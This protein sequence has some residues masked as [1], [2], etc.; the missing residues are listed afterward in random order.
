MATPNFPAPLKL[1]DQ[2][3]ILPAGKAVGE[4]QAALL[5]LH[6]GIA[7]S[8]IARK[9]L[10]DSTVQAL[11]A[12][13]AQVG[14]A[15]DGRI[16]PRT[17]EK[18]NAELAHRFVADSK[19]RTR[20]LQLLLEQ[21][22]QAVD[23]TEIR[24]R[25]FGDSTANALM[26]A[27]GSLG[28]TQ[29]GRVNAA[30]FER[31]REAA[32]AA[33]LQSKA[34]VGQL[35]RTLLRALRTAK[36]EVKVAPGELR[37]RTIGPSTQAAIQALQKKYHLR[38]TG[39]PDAATVDRMTSIAASIPPLARLL[40]AGQAADLQQLK[41]A[42]RLNMRSAHV[43]DVQRAL[44][45]LGFAVRES[46]FRGTVFGKSTRAAVVTYQKA[47]GLEVTGH[48]DGATLQSMNREIRR[49]NGGDAGESSPWR[50]RGCVR[51]A[52]WQ[53]VSRATV[54]VWEHPVSGNGARLAERETHG[55]GF[56]DLPYAPPRDPHT[57]RVREPFRLLVKVLRP[58][59]SQVG[60]RVLFNPTQIA[61]AN[62]T[63]G[64]QPYRGESVFDLRMRV[65]R[66]AAGV[67]RVAD[68]VETPAQRQVSAAAQA[69]GLLPE[70][71]MQLLLAHKVS[72]ALKDAALGPEA[73]YA[74]LAQKLPPN[75]PGDLIGATQDWT[76]VDELVTQATYGLVFM[77]DEAKSNAFGQ[78]IT[79]NLMP[80]AVGR[81]QEE[82]LLQFA[83]VKRRF[84]LAEPI[85][86]GNG[87]LDAVL[88]SSAVDAGSYDDV[89]DTFLRH[90]GFGAAFWQDVEARPADF[91]GAA[92]VADLKATVQ[93][94][95]VTKNFAPLVAR[96]KQKMADPG[97]A[98]MQTPR[99]LA[100]LT[101]D[102]WVGILAAGGNAVPPGTDAA[103]GDPVRTY[104]STLASTSERLFPDVALVAEVAR[105]GG[106]ALARVAQVQQVMDANPEL[107]LRE[108]NIDA[109]VAERHLAVEPDTLAEARVLQ[110][111]S[112]IAPS[113][114]T[115][116]LLV[117]NRIH[118][119]A[120]IVG[121]GQEQFVAQLT[122][123]PAVDTRTARTMYQVAESRYAGVLQRLA[124]YRFE[125]HRADPRA[126]VRHT[127]T[128]TE[129]A[130]Y[131]VA[132][133]ETLFGS[134]DYCAC[135]HC[136]SVY[137]P[138]AYLAD[139]LRFLAAHRS[140]V[141]NRSVADLFFARRPDVRALKLNCRNTETALPY[142][143][144]VNE[145]LEAAV[146]APQPAPAFAFQST[147]TTAEL[148]AAPENV[149]EAAY[150]KLRSADFPPTMSFDLW[151][152]QARVFLQHLGVPRW[153]LM[154]AFQSRPAAGAAAPSAGSI[155]G[156]FWGLSTHE[157]ALVGAQNHADADRQ[158][159][160]WG[161]PANA[162]LPGRLAVSDFLRRSGLDYVQL[163]A[164]LHADWVNPPGAANP[165]VIERPEA[166]CNTD[167]QQLAN[168]D[169]ARLDRIHRFLRL[170]RRT[171]WQ[172]WELDL[173]LR[174]GP[175]GNGTLDVNALAALQKF[176]QV[177]KRLGLNVERGLALYGDIERRDR[178]RPE[179]PQETVPALYQS[180]FL[181]RA[182]IS[183]VD[184][185][186]NLPLA[187][188]QLDD[189]KGT[190]LAAFGIS[191]ADLARIRARLPDGALT[192]ANLS[193][194][195]RYAWLAQGLGLAVKDLLTFESLAGIA[196]VFASP[197]ATSDFIERLDWIRK[198]G[199]NIEELDYALRRSPD[200][201]LGLRDE[202]I[203][204][205]AEALRDAIRSDKTGNAAGVATSQVAAALQVASE[206]AK[207]LAE[208]C[209]IGSRTVAAILVE[210]NFLEVDAQG[211][212][213]RAATP[214]AF[215]DLF[216][217][218]RALHKATTVVQRFKL[219]AKNL[220]WLLAHA[221]AHGLLRVEALPITA[222]PA[223]PLFP[224]WLNL[225]K[226][227][228]FKQIHPEP[229][230]TSLRAVLDLAAAAATT[231]A[232]VEQDLAALT[233]WDPQEVAEIARA[234]ALNQQRAQPQPPGSDFTVIDNYVR[235]HQARLLAWR[236][237]VAPARAAAWA[238]RDTEANQAPLRAAQEARQAAKAKYDEAT[239]LQ[240]VTPLEDTLRERKR[241]ALIAYL[242]ARSQTTMAPTIVQGTQVYANPEYFRDP[243]DLLKYYLI[244]VEMC[245][246]QLTSR[247]K[248][249]ISSVQMFV[250]RC[251]LG[252]EQPRVEVSRSQQ[253]EQVSE[254]SWRQW[255]WMKNYRVW[256]ANRKV[257]LYPENWI[258]PE[259]RDD[260]SPFF[261]EFEEEL[262][263]ADITD[264]RA[265][266]ALLRYLE[267]THEVARLDIVGAYHELDDSDT[268]DDLPP[269]INRLHVIG[270]TRT[271]PTVHYY[272]NFD[273]NR[274]EWTAWERIDLDIESE[275]VVPVV[276]NR[277][278]H[279][280]WLMFLEKPQKVKRLPAAQ[281]SSSV[282]NP[283]PPNV[284]EIQ[285][286]WSARAQ[287]G[288]ASKRVS[289][290]KLVHPWQRPRDSY[291]LK[292]RYKS[293]TNLLWVDLYIS[294]SPG[295]NSTRF[296][297]PYR[298]SLR[299]VTA[300]HPHDETARPWHAS[301]FVFDG[302][303]VDIRMRA[304]TGHYH[305]LGPD[306]VPT[307][308][309]TMTDSLEYVRANFGEL[310]RAT[311]GLA[312]GSQIAPRLPLPDGMHYSNT[313][314]ANNRQSNPRRANVLERSQSR[315]LLNR[316]IAPFEIVASQHRI[317]FDTLDWGQVPFF[318]QDPRRAWFVRPE[319]EQVMA[320]SQQTVQRC[321]YTFY[322]FHHPYTALFMRELRRSGV[323]GLLQRRIQVAPED[324]HPANPF[325]FDDYDPADGIA[326]PDA[327]TGRR[328]TVDFER[329]GAYAL[330]NWELFFHAPLL[331]ACKLSQN[332][333]FEEAMRW[334]HFIFDPTNVESAEVPQRYWV[335][336]P[337]FE[338]NSEAYRR[339]RI[340]E[341]LRNIDAHRDQLTAWK[342]NP[343]K[344][345]LI[346][347][348]RPVAYQK[349]VV[350][351]YIDNLIA[352][353]DHLFRRDTIEAINEAT[354]LY[355]L[356]Y[357]IL[358]RRP[359]KV[360]NVNATD[361]SYA[362]LTQQ[363]GLDAFGNKRVE[364]LLENHADARVR[365]TRAPPGTEPLPVLDVSYFGI[366]HNDQMLAY[367][368]R[369]ED[370]LYKI[371]HCMNIQGVVRQLPLFEPPIDPAL[372][373]K[374]AAAGVD[375]DSA[376]ADLDL[377]APPYR[378]RF[379]VAKAQELCAVARALGDK[380][381]AVL[382]KSDGEALALLRSRHEQ[383]LLKAVREI[384][385]QQIKE[386]TEAMAGLQKTRELADQRKTFYEGREFIN[387]WEGAAL[388]LGGA[389]AVA[390]T[391]IALGYVLAGGL[392]FIPGFVTGAS[393]FGGSP[394]VT[395]QVVDG[396]KFS[397][398][399]ELATTTLGAI[400]TALD[401]YA[402]LSSAVGGYQ[403]RQDEWTFQAQQAATELQQIDRQIAAA[404]I[405]LA[406]AEKELE[407]QELQIDNAQAV[408]EYM[409]NKYTNRQLYDWQV[410]QLSAVYF[411]AYQLAYDIGKRA[412]KCFRQER[413]DGT[414]VFVQFGHWDSLKGGLLAGERLAND[415][416][417]MEAAFLIDNARDLEL[418]RH[419][420][421]AQHFPLAL[422]EL[423]EAGSCT[424]RLDE[425][426]FDMDHPGH[427]FR[428]LKSVS[429]S[430]PSVV[431]PYTSVNCRLTLV[432]N[433]IRVDGGLS[434]GYGDPLAAAADTRFQQGVVAQRAI[435]TSHGQN[436]AGM[437]EVSFNDERYLPFE[438]AGAVSEWRLE[439]PRD[440]NQFDIATV[441]DVVLHVRYTAR[442]SGNPAFA[443][444]AR[445][446]LDTLL[447]TSGARLFMLHRE[448]ASEWH[449]FLHPGGGGAQ[450]LRLA[451]GREHLPF[452]ARD[453]RRNVTLTRVVLVADGASDGQF[454]VDLA[455]PGQAAI[456]GLAL[457]A[458]PDYGN[459]ATVSRAGFPQNAALVGDWA[460]TVRRSDPQD[461]APIA[462]AELGNAY[463]VLAFSART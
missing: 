291:N 290:Q 8:D 50:V 389:S 41:K 101:V 175:V 150:D 91:G 176:S 458:D 431:G 455:S 40:K 44:A 223:A 186:F 1:A 285:L 356:A 408:D 287:D 351:K 174:A 283:E 167:L 301:S 198:A 136:R 381:L 63:E 164:L 143:D 422:L 373:V 26:K 190:V 51:D 216:N 269:D 337:F 247:I 377:P 74:F 2:A 138:A 35:Q 338:T 298:S 297:D 212:F 442:D 392:A 394:H 177:Q 139:L 305:V 203:A 403:R 225:A 413:G 200:S 306:G 325:A 125:L 362:E 80:I 271:H 354:T 132:N 250:Q 79:A 452:Y 264:E 346:A 328:E 256:E 104:A 304:L 6:L 252:L 308:V 83:T 47:R 293:L 146:D 99:D 432:R 76:L 237:G 224:D 369:V 15:A 263:Q 211:R 429:L 294:Q 10:G 60:T 64:D 103:S 23:P 107:D 257:F 180:L 173:L 268:G 54:E 233:Q 312:G 28:L 281:E 222:E 11:R 347:R 246:C 405:R 454:V 345:H 210:A 307:G 284:M 339:Q 310:G 399:S 65:L 259:L 27:Q 380:L 435:A 231:Q 33:R 456:P 433:A 410:R 398:A 135:A 230:Q 427:L 459:R 32:L 280:F 78:A 419:F 449:R 428:R 440:S 201:P 276:Y 322:P 406:L 114:T 189:H 273:L 197:R 208:N 170:W 248:Q 374:A 379:A 383:A 43:A 141:Q 397:K 418:T 88:K 411:Q 286:C 234:L 388:A 463:L 82:I 303:V 278:L 260:K 168:L 391:G 94:G 343:F 77:D 111:I 385:K 421:L 24:T 378:F 159:N 368:D 152:E 144:L 134:L 66:K 426:L 205:L 395:V 330:Y 120:Q 292:P 9:E 42:A 89:A 372:L 450:V 49:A 187:P 242:M 20:A 110:R 254:N 227:T 148:R 86:V 153:E 267:K 229:E 430:I 151:Q 57:G 226:F 358:G 295:F 251:L 438:G 121:M 155:A 7:R 288:W 171:G 25:S 361:L 165:M 113:A 181:S 439:L 126:I 122:K 447:P 396:V 129:L 196:D 92:A 102:D 353:G 387:A 326:L 317:R 45:F 145:V 53:P 240:K 274:G 202:V 370:R 140:E 178:V 365:I 119:S 390:Q 137:G 162:P 214:A 314:L 313:R 169:A 255:R 444:A 21:A 249:A 321:T 14:E 96:L 407:N 87:S 404:G 199:S 62:F 157:T 348:Y 56:F 316:A 332:Q 192:L 195:G 420:S 453:S 261:Q 289:K 55:N 319:I 359:E 340:D 424:V 417:R 112:R 460:F 52:L 320:G 100:K 425:W 315:T 228:W 366:P 22:G 204:Q 436:D 93:I 31:L 386:A 355:V 279:L 58:D 350:M 133:V 220:E 446:R 462:A 329:Y 61:W 245:A 67:D 12:F 81:R 349:T 179:S 333:R 48:A 218:W 217:A 357:E 457:N 243:N 213:L 445:A 423:K 232:Q 363:A 221:A 253:Q 434:G 360:P 34:Q 147:R 69:A 235:M 207:L 238:L 38:A 154:E 97:D 375:L 5:R 166:T 219:D 37:D 209:R 193:R 384:R 334:F 416:S 71:V 244:D 324:F 336:R 318:Y 300:R 149:R 127:Y 323:Q 160:F 75:I 401:K 364:V 183:P 400:A 215:G 341:L 236:A 275:Q 367:W 105:S 194:I 72:A 46:E 70:D 272:R 282:D 109:F 123:D 443:A 302:D 185:A 142:V 299:Y 90:R 128:P 131:G 239:W 36:L 342:N 124:D 409:R 59:G 402:S 3:N 182:V 19:P 85:L 68:L 266:E 172:M 191:E 448:F 265:E 393:G 29:D 73:C 115:G 116:R 17:V 451:L 117:Q 30:V 188:A 441:A 161:L 158:R 156:E 414:A 206:Q 163:L 184:P 371:R 344:P 335:T 108:S 412:E 311:N 95:Q 270:R 130:D 84:A 376:L 13:Q 4:I 106:H 327:K 461:V 352:W 118:S 382:E 437:F 39:E 309:L 262:L 98:S 277:R 415:L 241:D 296:W 331:V 258:E 16:T 18:L